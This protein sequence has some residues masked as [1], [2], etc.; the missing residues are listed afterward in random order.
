MLTIL[1]TGNVKRRHIVCFTNK[2]VPVLKNSKRWYIDGTFRIIN[3]PFMQMWTI[4]AF[5]RFGNERK[6]VP[7]CF[8]NV[9]QGSK[10]LH[11]FAEAHK[12]AILGNGQN[13]NF[14]NYDNKYMVITGYYLFVQIRP[15]RMCC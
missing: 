14:V 1:I 6:M 2:Q 12:T 15:E 9:E 8:V 4:H 7:L 3:K 5:I 13:Y 11:K 10:V